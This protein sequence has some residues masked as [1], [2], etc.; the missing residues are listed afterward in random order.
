M[1]TIELGGVCSVGAFGVAFVIASSISI[2]FGS[3]SSVFLGF[4]A[5]ILAML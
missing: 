3:R 1:G 2:V 5:D 4:G